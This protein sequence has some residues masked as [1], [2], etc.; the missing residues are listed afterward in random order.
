METEHPNAQVMAKPLK[1]TEM[2]WPQPNP[3]NPRSI[4]ADRLNKLGEALAR[5]GDLGGIVFNR[6]CKVWSTVRIDGV[7]SRMRTVCKNLSILRDRHRP[8]DS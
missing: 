5:Y 7:I 3:V 2:E 8:T 6:C 1:K 4:S